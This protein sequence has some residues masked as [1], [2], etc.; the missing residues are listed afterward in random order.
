MGLYRRLYNVLYY[1]NSRKGFNSV[2]GLGPIHDHSN[3]IHII[4]S[5]SIY[6]L[7][8]KLY[9]YITAIFAFLPLTLPSS[10]TLAVGIV[11]ISIGFEVIPSPPLVDPNTVTV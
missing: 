8:F 4:K 5:N 11:G 10:V 6:K 2:R 1:E 9:C 7:T 3:K